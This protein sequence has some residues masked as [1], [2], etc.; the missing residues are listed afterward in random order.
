MKRLD[1]EE[2]NTLFNLTHDPEESVN[3]IDD[4]RYKVVVTDLDNRLTEFFTT[5][6]DEKY[7]LWQGG[8]AKGILLDKYYG[9][10]DVFRD[11]FPD[12]KEPG[13]EKATRIF[14]DLH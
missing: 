11:R 1:D 9:R 2:S 4:P 12:W 14:T 13:M 7:D 5:Y 10:D 8:T 3:L 6:A